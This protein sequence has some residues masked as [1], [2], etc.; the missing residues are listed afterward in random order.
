MHVDNNSQN[1]KPVRRL[2]AKGIAFLGV[3]LAFAIVL[4]LIGGYTDISTLSFMAAAAFCTGI[5]IREC[6]FFLG[7]GFGIAGVVLAFILAPNKLYV[8]TY[9]CMSLYIF[10][11]EWIFERIAG[12]KNFRR[13]RLKFWLFKYLIFNVMY[14][15]VLIFLPEIILDLVV[16]IGVFTSTYSVGR[17]RSAS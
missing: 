6:G 7:G 5:A 16:V 10:A 15:P 13:P 3:L 1:K 9:A 8:M 4:T 11:R 17:S 2:N 14:I 12:S